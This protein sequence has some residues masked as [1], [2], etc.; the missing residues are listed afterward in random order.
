MALKKTDPGIRFS[1]IKVAPDE[2]DRVEQYIVYGPSV[3]GSWFGTAAAGTSTQAKPLVI[4]GAK[5]DYPRN[6]LGVVAGSADMGGAWVVNGR[7][8]FGD[9]IQETITIGTAANG[10]TVAGT[11]IFAEVTS[12]TFTFTTGAVGSGTPTLGVAIGTA[13]NTVAQFGIPDKIGAVSDVKGIFWLDSDTMKSVN[14]GTV[15]ST[16]VDVANNSFNVGQV[17]AAADS[18]IIRYRSTYSSEETVQKL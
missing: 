12:G 17:V 9:V 16:Y 4:L 5:A 15:T 11:K 1:G 7:T 13:V 2:I 3:S 14:S 8:Q 10:G 18:F 6:L